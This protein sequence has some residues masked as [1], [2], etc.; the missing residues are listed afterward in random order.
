MTP[1]EKEGKKNIALFVQRLKME[2]I[3]NIK[4]WIWVGNFFLRDFSLW[5]NSTLWFC[6]IGPKSG[7]V[8]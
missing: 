4:L 7:L 5:A 2:N 8:S 6:Q 3:Q 1:R